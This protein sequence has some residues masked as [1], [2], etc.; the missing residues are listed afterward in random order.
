MDAACVP[1]Q[2]GK[3]T[4]SLSKTVPAY[5]F[6]SSTRDKEENRFLTSA[7]TVRTRK[8]T[9]SPAN[10][11][12]QQQHTLSSFGKQTLASRQSTPSYGF[13]SAPRLVFKT[14]ATPGPGAYD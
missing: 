1:L 8:G 3:Q 14:S 13:G 5:G 4:L 7:H 10:Y 11:G 6:G 2:I 9:E 12:H